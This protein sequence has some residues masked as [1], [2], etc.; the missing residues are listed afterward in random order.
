[1]PGCL[2]LAGAAVLLLGVA[3]AVQGE[4]RGA[5]TTHESGGVSTH[6]D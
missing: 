5:G 3:G 1:V 2:V 4:G 6:A